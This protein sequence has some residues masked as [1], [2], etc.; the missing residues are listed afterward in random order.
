MTKLNKI[1]R[2]IG[3]GVLLMWVDGILIGIVIGLKLRG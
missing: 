1:L 2:K 3:V